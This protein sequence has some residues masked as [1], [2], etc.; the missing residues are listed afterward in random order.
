MF[1]IQKTSTLFYI[2]FFCKV[3]LHTIDLTNSD[4]N[5]NEENSEIENENYHDKMP[6]TT[7]LFEDLILIFISKLYN[8][9]FSIWNSQKH[10]AFYIYLKAQ[11][12]CIFLV[13]YFFQPE[14]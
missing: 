3:R 5:V 1:P 2:A 13:N 6:N 4:E 8:N 12:G 11:N 10:K 14:P 7:G 9:F